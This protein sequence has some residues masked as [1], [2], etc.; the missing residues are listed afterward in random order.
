MPG[1]LGIWLLGAGVVAAMLFALFMDSDTPVRIGRGT[2][3]PAFEL[4]RAGGGSSLS[5]EQLRGKVVLFNFWATWC[6]PCED[7]MPAME[8]LYRALAGTDF[9]LV[10]ISVDED[11][12]AVVSFVDRLGLSFP[13]LMD[14]SQQ[15]SAAYQT[16]R[17]PESLL[18]GRDG[19]VLERYV[20]PKEWDA[21]AYVD[22]IRRLLANAS[23]G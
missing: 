10:A 13:V 21:D 23:A 14:S 12:A 18:V 15:V 22:R 20:G 7:E 8:R 5:L 2:S 1:R 6:K 9:E 11:E 17:F 3:A 4:R 16:F 19:V